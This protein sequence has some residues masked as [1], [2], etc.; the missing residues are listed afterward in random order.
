MTDYAL[1][2]GA[3]AD[4]S[5]A[6]PPD[7]SDASL[8]FTG[9][10]PVDV[11]APVI[12]NWS[13]AP[14]RSVD[15]GGAILVRAFDGRRLALVV[16]S[17]RY[18]ALGITELVFDGA[19]FSPDYA[20]SSVATSATTVALQISRSGGFL[21]A[22][23]LLVVAVDASG[24]V[25]RASAAFEVS[26]A[27][28]ALTPAPANAVFSRPTLQTLVDRVRGDFRAL[29]GSEGPFWSRSLENALAKS[30]PGMAHGLHGHLQWVSEQVLPDRCGDEGVLRWARILGLSLRG[31]SQSVGAAEF[32]ASAGASVP[33]GARLTSTAGTVYR[34]TAE[35]VESGGVVVVHVESVDA[36]IV[37]VAAAGD[38]LTLESPIVGV[39]SVGA[40]SASGLSGGRDADTIEVLRRRVLRRLASPPRGGSTADYREWSLE[41]DSV[42]SVDV[43]PDGM[44]PG[45]VL[46]IAAVAGEDPTPSAAVLEALASHLRTRKPGTAK[47]HVLGAT[48]ARVDIALTITPDTPATRASVVAAIR[49]FFKASSGDDL[50]YLSQLGEAISG[51]TGEVD[52]RLLSPTADVHLGVGVRAVLGDVTWSSV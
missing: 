50:L 1:L 6:L 30:V 41:V 8:I 29:E 34:S 13:P 26:G 19:S 23:E 43:V 3:G 9:A 27:L 45:T 14:G 51:A 20:A 7:T 36:G 12:D 16:V 39:A 32:S 18:P 46:V 11:V 10:C 4:A 21:D 37:T 17:A 15:R 5:A 22:L 47:V 2:Y 28:G 31:A 42:E 25:S 48:V 33:A 40:V 49:D 24:N 38:L 52:H 35:S 44:G